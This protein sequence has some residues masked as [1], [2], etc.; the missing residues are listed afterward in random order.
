M[1]SGK[2]VLGVLAGLA[3][4]AALGVLFAP[5]SGEA[6]RRK[7][8]EKGEDFL[9]DAK[10]KIQD[11][12]DDLHKQVDSAKEKVKDLE[13]KIHQKTKEEPTSN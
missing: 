2:V 13:T 11:L 3:A 7:I 1:S 9:D 10:D 5:D 6:T 4:G 8:A 12:M